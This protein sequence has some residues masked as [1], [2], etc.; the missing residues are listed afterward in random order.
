MQKVGICGD[1][2]I[3]ELCQILLLVAANLPPCTQCMC[4]SIIMY[5][6]VLLESSA[7]NGNTGD[8]LPGKER[9]GNGKT[10]ANQNRA[11]NLQ[12]YS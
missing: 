4:S 11:S 10:A 9:G 6:M 1:T 3:Y 12:M 5:A 8:S 7:F 2:D